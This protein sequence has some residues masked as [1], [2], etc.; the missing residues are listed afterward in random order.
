MGRGGGGVLAAVLVF[1]TLLALACRG[2]GATAAAAATGA[3]GSGGG[4]GSGGS[5]G[6]GGGGGS[7]TPGE[8]HQVAPGGSLVCMVWTVPDG[9]Q[10]RRCFEDPTTEAVVGTGD[11]TRSVRAACVCVCVCARARVCG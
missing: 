11:V 6:S 8:S 4:G 9:T 2:A 5:G 10:Y 3:P 1:A 7:G